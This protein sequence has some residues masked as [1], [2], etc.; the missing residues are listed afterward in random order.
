MP[1]P[2]VVVVV[3]AMGVALV[4]AT[5]V[6]SAEA[7]VALAPA[8]SVALVQVASRMSATA[9]LA[10]DGTTSPAAAITTT[11]S[12]ARIIHI[13]HP[14]IRTTATTERLDR[15]GKRER[16]T[17]NSLNGLTWR[18]GKKQNASSTG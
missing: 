17:F 15:S 7:W 1:K 5:W 4:E 18:I 12:A 2:A 3:A 16:A 8:A 14:T 10:S 13:P 6:V 9:A 11:D